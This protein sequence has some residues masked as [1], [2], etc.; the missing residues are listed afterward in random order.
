MPIDI[1]SDSTAMPTGEAVGHG[2]GAATSEGPA[3]A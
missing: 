3:P 2:A 1:R